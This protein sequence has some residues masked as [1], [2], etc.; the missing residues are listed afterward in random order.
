MEGLKT[1]A[2]LMAIAARTAPKSR[3]EDF[4]EIKI[5]EGNDV[6]KIA[7]GMMKFSEKSKKTNHQAQL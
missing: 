1:V 3:G 6:K 2:E 4:I 7:E 5:V